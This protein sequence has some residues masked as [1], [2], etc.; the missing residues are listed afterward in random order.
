MFF[1]SEWIVVAMFRILSSSFVIHEYH[2]C[3]Q[4]LTWPSTSR[5]LLY[6]SLY[7]MLLILTVF[8]LPTWSMYV[9]VMVRHVEYMGLLLDT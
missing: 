4:K 5:C 3:A 7:Y 8:S 2:L 1:V 9:I 6:L